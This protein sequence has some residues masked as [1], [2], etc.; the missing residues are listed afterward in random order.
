ML[1]GCPRQNINHSSE[2]LKV[3][4]I[5]CSLFFAI[6][7][8]QLKTGGLKNVEKLVKQTGSSLSAFLYNL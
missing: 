8:Y 2:N 1:F 4:Y 6:I 3:I 7:N 5:K